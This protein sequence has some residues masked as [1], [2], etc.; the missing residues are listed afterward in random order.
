MLLDNKWWTYGQCSWIVVLCW[1]IRSR[2][3]CFVKKIIWTLKNNL[4]FLLPNTFN[5]PGAKRQQ[6]ANIMLHSST[7][8]PMVW[9]LFSHLNIASPRPGRCSFQ[10]PNLLSPYYYRHVMM[11]QKNHVWSFLGFAEIIKKLFWLSFQAAATFTS[12][13]Q[14]A[15][16]K[17]ATALWRLTRNSL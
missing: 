4:P 6:N 10:I 17:N 11:N 12:D 13:P 3:T 15:P 16:M 9:F 14:G 5:P 2:H 7:L 1:W 8:S